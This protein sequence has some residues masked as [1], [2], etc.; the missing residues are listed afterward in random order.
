MLNFLA[1][2]VTRARHGVGLNNYLPKVDYNELKQL[3]ESKKRES[4]R[5]LKKVKQIQQRATQSH[6]ENLIKQHQ[7]AWNHE[8]Q[9][10]DKSCKSLVSEINTF[11]TEM[12]KNVCFPTEYDELYEYY[13]D[14]ECDSDAFIK[15]T[16]EPIRELRQENCY[17]ILLFSFK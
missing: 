13:S 17:E 16:L 10:L 8:L 7:L 15:E 4:E 2:L 9:H 6:E 3:V 12:L 5:S 1:T 11:I 14:L